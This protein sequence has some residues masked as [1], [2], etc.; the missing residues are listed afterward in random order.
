VR[1][2]KFCSVE[3]LASDRGRADCYVCSTVRAKLSVL[4]QLECEH[5][6]MRRHCGKLEAQ[7][8]Q[9]RIKLSQVA[10][11]RDKACH[12]L[13]KLQSQLASAVD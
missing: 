13:A 11:E 10:E 3:C 12:K 9:L 7:N 1:P 6:E 8:E 2:C 4:S 5:H